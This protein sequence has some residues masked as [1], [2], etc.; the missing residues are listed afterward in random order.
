M[1]Q[2]RLITDGAVLLAIYAVLLLVSRYIPIVGTVVMF[3][4]PIPFLIF[5]IRYPFRSACMLFGAALLVTVI[6]SSPLSIVNTFMSG[7]IGISLGYMYKKQKSPAGI[8]L[9]GTLVY[10]I[11]FV[12]IYVVSV[13]FFNID[14]I[15]QMQDTF[16][17]AMEQ[18]E[19]MM[20]VVG[21]P[22]NPEQKE[23][24]EQLGD[25][26]RILLPSL[27]VMV[28]FIYSWITVLMA[29][30]VLRRLK[31]KVQPWPQFRDM[32]L[33]KS[34]VW[35]YVLFILLSTFMKVESDSYAN[36]AFSNLYAIFSLLLFFQGFSFISF[37]T[38]VKGY[39]KAIPI[40]IFVIGM[41]VPM[42]F[43]LVII[44]GIIDLGFALRSKI[45]SK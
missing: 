17:Q 8:L 9:V 13:K 42:L 18:S 41:F 31:C 24:F 39:T 25:T 12:L 11:N 29:G 4:L 34:I 7:I 32:Q 1:K 36:M 28:S 27:L 26:L 44:L 23:M 2:T 33:P 43:P 37:F 19:K 30:N 16:R 14:F 40:F 20:K 3:A 6:V 21:A 35:Y 15:K 38:H 10:L 45:Q 5:M 22:V